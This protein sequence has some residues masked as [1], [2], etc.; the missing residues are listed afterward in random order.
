MLRIKKDFSIT[1]ISIKTL[2]YFYNNKTL[3]YLFKIIN[4][5]IQKYTYVWLGLVCTGSVSC[6]ALHDSMRLPPPQ[7]KKNYLQIRTTSLSALLTTRTSSDTKLKG[8]AV[9]KYGV[10]IMIVV[11]SLLPLNHQFNNV[12]QIYSSI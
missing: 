9:F 2:V 7:K 8:R 11:L 6:P 12:L 1:F 3:V 4:Q 10:T 5:M